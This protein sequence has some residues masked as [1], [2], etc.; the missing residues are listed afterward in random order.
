MYLYLSDPNYRA[1]NVYAYKPFIIKFRQFFFQI[2]LV[3]LIIY[4]LNFKTYLVDC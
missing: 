3:H 1:I 2:L 4:F